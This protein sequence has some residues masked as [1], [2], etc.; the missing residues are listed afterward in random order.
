MVFAKEK[1]SAFLKSSFTTFGLAIVA[2]GCYGEGRARPSM[3][4]PPSQ[5]LFPQPGNARAGRV[6]FVD[7]FLNCH[8][9]KSRYKVLFSKTV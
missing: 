6:L 7:N 8:S 3:P 2:F 9:L 1:A 4:S 5:R